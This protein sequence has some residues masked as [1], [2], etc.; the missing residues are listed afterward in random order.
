[1]IDKRLTAED[2]ERARAAA[3]EA[4]GELDQRVPAAQAVARHNE[5]VDALAAARARAAAERAAK[6]PR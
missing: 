1:M 2:L 3:D 5:L 4:S 6:K